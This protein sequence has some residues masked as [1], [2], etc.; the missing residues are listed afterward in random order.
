MW[1]NIV[2]PGRPQMTVHITCWILK[3]TNTHSQ[4]VILIVFPLKQ[5]L[6]ERAS[7]LRYAYFA[8]LVNV[9]R[10]RDGRLFEMRYDF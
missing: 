7:T 5:R 9:N 8:S 1:K 3:A 4:L 10:Q 2:Q 6:H